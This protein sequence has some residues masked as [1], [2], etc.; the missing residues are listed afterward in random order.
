[1]LTKFD[2]NFSHNATQDEMIQYSLM[3]LKDQYIANISIIVLSIVNLL[4]ALILIVRF[5]RAIISARLSSSTLH[6]IY[7]FK[8]LILLFSFDLFSSLFYICLSTFNLIGYVDQWNRVSAPGPCFFKFVIFQMIS[9]KTV[10]KF[11]AV[12]GVDRFLCKVFP[13]FYYERLD[14]RKYVLGMI[15]KVTI[16][17]ISETIYSVFRRISTVNLIPLCSMSLAMHEDTVGKMFT[18]LLYV[19]SS[20]IYVAGFLIL[21]IKKWQRQQ[22]TVN[23]SDDLWH[24]V[25]LIITLEWIMT[26]LI[27]KYIDAALPTNRGFNDLLKVHFSV[28]CLIIFTIF[29]PQFWRK[30]A[31]SETEKNVL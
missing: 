22:I 7:L 28:F 13:H 12:I 31:K 27:N 26:H 15:L 18:G 17:E 20:G 1:M 8:F 29:T 3:L 30:S 10:T 23:A 24:L 5:C 9:V 2:S 21:A 14:G 4:S 25:L 16:V 19:W 6:Q 11:L